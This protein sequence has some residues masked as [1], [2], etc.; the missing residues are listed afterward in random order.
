[1]R[2]QNLYNKQKLKVS[3][4]LWE[5]LEDYLRMTYILHACGEAYIY[6][7]YRNTDIKSSR[8]CPVLI[9]FGSLKSLSAGK[10]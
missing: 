8:Q 4:G 7:T 1:M 3:I 2:G 9:P 10:L 5:V 6:Y